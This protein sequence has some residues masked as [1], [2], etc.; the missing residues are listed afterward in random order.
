MQKGLIYPSESAIFATFFVEN[1]EDLSFDVLKQ[2][3][4]SI[5]DFIKKK[6][7]DYASITMGV[8]MTEWIKMCEKDGKKAP[9]SMKVKYEYQ[10]P[11][12]NAVVKGRSG[13]F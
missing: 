9:L 12:S 8:N 10:D 6:K 4:N 5:N 3:L 11:V 13:V 7:G 1:K 2:V